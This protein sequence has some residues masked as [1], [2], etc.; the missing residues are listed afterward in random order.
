V[1][2]N[3]PALLTRAGAPDARSLSPQARAQLRRDVVLAV[4]D[5]M[6]RLEAARRFGVSRR[7]V[8]IWMR[9]FQTGGPDPVRD[10]P[11]GTPAP[12]HPVLTPDQER[13][14]LRL[15]RA[16]HPSLLGLDGHLWTRRTVAEIIRIETGHRLPAG[17]VDH[18][19]SSWCLAS[20]ATTRPRPDVVLGLR[21]VRVSCH[22][23]T[24]PDGRHPGHP[25]V[26]AESWPALVAESGPGAVHFRLLAGPIGFDGVRAFGRHL[27]QQHPRP[28]SLFVWRWPP[29]QLDVLHAWQADPGPGLVITAA[30]D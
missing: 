16:T 17:T 21:T 7:T 19:L 22:T 18:Y 9:S 30:G 20:A 10:R 28:V 1:T 13:T 15:M 8:G 5:G 3:S 11:V 6:T 26:P 24:P 27:A 2:E 25:P 29:T 14:V 23:I 4:R 12:P